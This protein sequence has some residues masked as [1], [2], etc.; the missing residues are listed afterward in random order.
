MLIQAYTLV[1]TGFV[2]NFHVY[3]VQGPGTM[4]HKR[5]KWFS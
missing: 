3:R 1:A 4:V 5:K 2:A